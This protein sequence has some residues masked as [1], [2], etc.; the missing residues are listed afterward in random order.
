MPSQCTSCRPGAFRENR[1]SKPARDLSF[2]TTGNQQLTQ[3][4]K[5]TN[6]K[7]TSKWITAAAVIGLSASLAFAGSTTGEGHGHGFHGKW[8]HHHGFS[9]LA[10]KLNLSDA[11]K[12]QWKAI[13][14]SSHEQNAAFFQQSRETRKEFFTEKKAGDTAKADSLK[15]TMQS[16]RAQMKQ[17]RESE[18]QQFTKILTADQNAQFQTLKA[19]R[20][21]RRAEWQSKK[22]QK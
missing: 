1:E 7:I 20:A 3:P 9:K 4:A 16:Q 14:K 8:R 21:A 12:D 13:R 18:E 22:S 11:Q 15:A 6:V 10:S 17:I 19:E 2:R 5:E